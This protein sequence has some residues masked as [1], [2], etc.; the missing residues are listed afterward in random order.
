MIIIGK[1]FYDQPIDSDVK[2]YEEIRKLTT[3]QGEDYTTGC[4]LDYDYFKNNYR[5]IAVDL[6][7]QKQL[8]AD[9][10]AIQQ[11]EL[12]GQLKRL[13]DDGNTRDAGAD[14]S[15]SVLTV[16]EKIHERRFKFS[17]G[18]ETNYKRWKIIKKRKL[19]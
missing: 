19:N 1:N 6:N 18:T 14:Q 15:M 11:I 4:L 16:L 2:W 8:D 13:D 9:P 3:G 12:I 17:Q 10:K 7:R 5:L